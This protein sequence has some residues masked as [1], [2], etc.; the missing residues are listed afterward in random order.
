MISFRNMLFPVWIA[1]AGIMAGCNSTS[2]P[3]IDIL[4]IEGVTWACNVTT[5]YAVFGSTSENE[6]LLEVHLPVSEGDLLYMLQDDLQFYCRYSPENGNRIVV[7]F[8]TLQEVSVYLNGHLSYMELS[9]PASLDAFK[10]LSGPEI[11]QLSALHVKS[12]I[13]NDLLPIL[14]QHETSLQ[15]IG[16]ILEG[17]AGMENLHDLLSVIRP[18]F[19][20][21]DDYQGLPDPEESQ[22]LS[23]LELLWI[24]DNVP[25]LAKLASCC[26]NLESLIVAQWEPEPGELL[27]LA[28]LKKLQTFTLAES[29]LT[30][31]SV[32][33]FPESLRNLYLIS[34]DTLS[35]INTLVDLK[36]LNRLALTQCNRVQGMD[37]LRTIASLQWLSFPPNISHQDFTE[38][39]L[40][41]RQLEGVALIDCW[42]IEDL[43]PLQHLPELKTLVLQLEK[44]QLSMLDSLEQLKLVILTSEVFEDNPEWIK[45]LRLSLPNTTIVPGSGLCLGS[46][47]LILLL[48][49][50]LLFRY[51]FRQKV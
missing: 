1:I 38:L 35:D 44:E 46:G 21:I 5:S 30:S 18:R 8:D 10:K 50:I 33:E 4:Q 42:E 49:F 40:G 29:G 7:T 31:L 6:D 45:E 13:T 51:L 47:W 26:T 48:P 43:A 3:S 2:G 25:A 32:V 27:P 15:G 23:N 20:V 9:G 41:L 37:V 22:C 11:D 17:E 16:I 14:Q 28:G 39:T 12:S 36:N 34:C 19:L 24:E